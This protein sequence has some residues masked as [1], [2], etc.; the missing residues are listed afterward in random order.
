MT[1]ER[2]TGVYPAYGAGKYW[3]VESECSC[4]PPRHSYVIAR[5]GDERVVYGE[6]SDGG[7]YGI[8]HYEINLAHARFIALMPTLLDA[9]MDAVL[10]GRVGSATGTLC[11]TCIAQAKGRAITECFP[12]CALLD[13]ERLINQALGEAW[14]E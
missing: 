5:V 3:C 10:Q 11:R 1:G 4:N 7:T 9:A 8:G 12:W 14:H 6:Y 13:L 2:M